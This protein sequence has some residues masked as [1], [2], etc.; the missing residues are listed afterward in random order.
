MYIFDI[1]Q[2]PTLVAAVKDMF[3]S[4]G[5]LQLCGTAGHVLVSSSDSFY[6]FKSQLVAFVDYLRTGVRPFPFEETV[7]LMKLV[8]AGIKS[9]EEDGREVYLEEIL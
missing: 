8:I 2:E 6:S 3:S 7:E 1:V 9:R 5:V 4:F